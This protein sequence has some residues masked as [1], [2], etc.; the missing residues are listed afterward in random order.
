MEIYVDMHDMDDEFM[1]DYF[2]DDVRDENNLVDYSEDS[3]ED[4][5]ELYY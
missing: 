5:K 4:L 3:I 2:P 1:E